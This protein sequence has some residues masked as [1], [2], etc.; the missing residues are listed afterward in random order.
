ML[1]QNP[2]TKRLDLAVKAQLEARP[3]KAEVKP[4]NAGE[5]RSDG[6]GQFQFLVGA[7]SDSFRTGEV[8][9]A[10]TS[11]ET[12]NFPRPQGRNQPKDL[13]VG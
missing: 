1:S 6:V 7:N 2:A 5:E 4:T 3:L 11:S 9:R 8:Y 12:G 13:M 10:G